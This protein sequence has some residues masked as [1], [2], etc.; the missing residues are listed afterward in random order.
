MFKTFLIAT[1]LVAF[2]VACGGAKPAPEVVAAPE[3]A[4]VVASLQPE[5]PPQDLAAPPPA[6]IK[7]FDDMTPIERFELMKGTV[8]PRMAAQFTAF[9]G[10]HFAKVTCAT[11]HSA[12][13]KERNFKMP[14]PDLPKLPGD[15]AGFQKLMA[16]KPAMVKFM[17]DKVS[18]DMAT[19]LGEAPYDPKTQK[20]FGCGH[21][22]TFVQ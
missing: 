19:M 11:C 17:H 7:R 2:A 4:P 3:P 6:P 21:C 20:G 22:H 1:C 5:L 14:N 12:Q 16:E 13:A 9:D 10:Q 15:A 18:A 8:L